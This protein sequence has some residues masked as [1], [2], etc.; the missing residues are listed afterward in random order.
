MTRYVPHID[1]LRTIAVLS[2]FFFHLGFSGVDGGFV[3]VDIFFVISGYLITNILK[4]SSERGT[5]KL[6]AFYARRARRLFPAFVTILLAC[7]V[8]GLFLLSPAR[9]AEMARSAN[10]ALFSISNFFFYFNSGYF[11]LDSKHQILLHTWSLGVEEQFY[12]VWPLLVGLIAQRIPPKQ[13]LAWIIAVTL[14]GAAVCIVVT[15]FDPGLAFYMMPFRV[16]EFG[17]GALLCWLQKPSSHGK[18]SELATLTGLILIIA[19]IVW[20]NEGIA[21]PGAVVL[22]PCIGTALVIHYGGVSHTGSRFVGHA[23]MAYLGRISYSLYLV[24]WPLII[25]Y[26]Q[27]FGSDLALGDQ[28]AILVVAVIVAAAMQKYIELPFKE[29]GSFWPT[30]RRVAVVYAGTLAVCFVVFSGTWQQGGLP[31]RFQSQIR[32]ITLVTDEE[33][34]KRFKPYSAMCETR[35]WKSCNDLVDDQENLVILGDSHGIDGFNI[36]QPW[37]ASVHT[38][39]RTA[40]S[41][42]PMTEEDFEKLVKPTWESYE[43]C[44]NNSKLISDTGFY[45]DV[46]YVAISAH[47]YSYTPAYLDRFLTKADI[48]DRVGIL[49]FGNAPV[50]EDDLPELI[51]QHGT[52]AGLQEYVARSLVDKSWEFEEGLKRVAAKHGARFVSKFEAFCDPDSK[53][54]KIFIGDDE[55]LLTYDKHHLSLDA[56]NYL[57]LELSQRNQD[58]SSLFQPSGSSPQQG[59]QSAR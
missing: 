11:D 55:K 2:V 45:A 58:I 21:F 47:Y 3:G 56:A 50:F 38:V 27:V 10:Y 53:T 19:S 54:C 33:K 7:L 23:A 8:A 24:H 6:S 31:G 36:L 28:L 51:V 9:L 34:Q 4:T 46:S 14:V 29:P 39:L 1:G 22:V 57:G 35:G 43:K 42:P 26:Q 17:I 44:R 5:L 13:Q 18:L 32:D 20:I 25:Y 30:T 15:R 37:S 59:F 41:C 52:L 48:P 12:L 49:I 16:G 40:T